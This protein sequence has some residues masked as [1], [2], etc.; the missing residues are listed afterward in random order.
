MQQASSKGRS[1]GRIPQPDDAS[2]DRPLRSVIVTLSGS[3]SYDHLFQQVPQQVPDGRVSVWHFGP[4]HFPALA[5]ILDGTRPGVADAD[6]ARDLDEL[7]AELAQVP[8]E[9]VVFNW[10]CCGAWSTTWPDQA[11]FRRLSRAALGRQ[12]L[13]MFGDF[14]MRSLIDGWD[15]SYLGPNPFRDL[16][17]T[18]GPM[19]LQFDAAQLV[20][21]DSVQLQTVGE[22]CGKGGAVIQT[23][24]GTLVFGVDHGA[25]DTSAY[26]LDVLT[27]AT[28][29]VSDPSAAGYLCA[30]GEH[31]GAVGHAM[32]RY[33]AGGK[34]LCSSGHWIE[35]QRLDV[36]EEAFLGTVA[37][38]YGGDARKKMEDE[39]AAAPAPARQQRL[40][41][42]SKDYVQRASPTSLKK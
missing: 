24:G 32:L 1:P 12:H 5:G 30:V 13:L 8:A 37:M 27:I 33:P 20:A 4:E 39:L 21:C 18:S 38:Q 40:Q 25:A 29:V 16:G 35:L 7:R 6:L 31:R 42:L 15:P 9:N 14:A 19:Q 22:L 28:G 23:M 26:R 3:N 34:I 17:S 2:T 36:S 41:D 10:E 11:A